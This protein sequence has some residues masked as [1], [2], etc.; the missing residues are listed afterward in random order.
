MHSK[1]FLQTIPALALALAASAWPG[2]AQ[3]TRTVPNDD[4]LKKGAD[5]MPVGDYSDV[6]PMPL[7]KKYQGLRVSDVV[8]AMQAIGLQDIGSMNRTIKPL[9]R[10]TTPAVSHRIYGVAV[11]AQYVPTNM[12]MS[13]MP[14][15]EF[16]KWHSHWYN[17]YA[18]EAFVRVIRP[19]TVVVIDAHGTG[20]VGFI[21][22]NNSLNWKSRGMAGVVTNAGARDTDEIILEKVPVY[23]AYVSLGTR[24]G[25]IE[26]ASINK[27]VSV[28][29]ALVRPGDMIVADGDGVVVVPREHAEEVAAIAW[30]VAKGDKEGRRKLY[31]KMSMPLDD[32][33]ER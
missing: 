15:D 12:R 28:G 13:K 30:D 20:D 1:S 22:S 19:G 18:P 4:E 3:E 21:G 17:N 24:P 5:L 16:R 25:R 29:G 31:Q 11:T 2:L 32:T 7:V 23:C 26:T 6:D 9:W 33:V 27:P 14:L 10:D 8:D